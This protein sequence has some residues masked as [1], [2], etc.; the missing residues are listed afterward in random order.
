M[1]LG[2]FFEHFDT[3]AE[4][5]N[6]I[7]RL[8]E[9]I[10]DMA[11]RGKL[12][13]QDPGDKPAIDAVQ[14]MQQEKILAEQSRGR[15]VK[16]QNLKKPTGQ[17]KI[18][19]S[20]P[21]NWILAELDSVCLFIDYRGKTPQKIKTGIRLVT[22][23]NVRNGFV[24]IEPKEF[25]SEETYQSWMTRGTPQFGDVLFTTEAP[26]GNAAVVDIN[27]RFALAQ[28]VINLHPFS[29]LDGKFLMWLILSPWF[30]QELMER[31]TGMT[32]QGIKASKLKLVKVP[33][34][35]LAEQKRIVAKVDELMGLCDVLEA[36]QQ[37]RNTLRQ[38]LRA[39]ALD[40][41][42]NASC[43][44]TLETSWAFVRDKWR[45]ICDRPEDVEGVRQVILQH[46][47]E[48]K[49]T[50]RHLKDRE[51]IHIIENALQ[52]RKNLEKNKK[53][54]KR[55]DQDPVKEDDLEFKLPLKWSCTRFG[56]VADIM[57][58][59]TKGRKLT[60]KMTSW[61]PYL[62][63]ANV[64]RWRLNLEQIK[65]IE[66][67]IEELDKYQ[68]QVG[69]I[70]LTEGG[71]WD[72]LGRSAI[73][74]GEITNC[75]HQNHVFRARLLS[76]EILA[77]WV[78]LF[79]N[80]YVGRKYFEKAAKRTTNL[81]SINMTQLRYCPLPIPPAEEQKRIVAKVD[82]LMQLCDQLEESLRSQQQ[83]AEALT[84]S[85]ISHLAA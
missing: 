37:N 54:T 29:G 21:K 62:R 22:A 65:E 70:L 35:P 59:V 26:L 33:L 44:R 43:D 50:C 16:K 12:V 83:Q 78:V 79:T 2:T 24:N 25:V 11:V 84:A 36:A 71:D 27:E 48:G 72:K 63:V 40:A 53:I 18:N 13:P 5:P 7:Q 30:Q 8:R 47:V 42:M 57:S 55:K 9:L 60:G 49:L 15:N 39:S 20:L 69:D 85:A 56:D 45:A 3:L 41:L 66:I 51:A 64:Q 34:P 32:A 77:E 23:K 31:A 75:I 19:F 14:I 73:W 61:H 38:N 74:R 17:Y 82:E 1:D 46:A 81:A 80:S 76:D 28:R 52:N 67:S 6:G 10:L 58:G 68:L 4:A